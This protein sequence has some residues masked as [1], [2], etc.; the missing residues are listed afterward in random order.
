VQERPHVPPAVPRERLELVSGGRLQVLTAGDGFATRAD[1]FSQQVIQVSPDGRRLAWAEATGMGFAILH[2]RDART[3]RVVAQGRLADFRFSPDSA[4]IAALV[5]GKVMRVDL[6]TGSTTTTELDAPRWVEWNAMGLVV[7]HRAP[8]GRDAITLLPRWTHPVTVIASHAPVSRLTTAAKTGKIAWFEDGGAT[9]TGRIW[10][11]DLADD[12]PKPRQAGTSVGGRVLNAE[13]APDGSAYAWV[14]GWGVFVA[15]GAMPRHEEAD[16]AVHSLWYGPDGEL[17][18]AS[19]KRVVVI[20]ERGRHEKAVAART[21]RFR[22]DGAGLIIVRERDAVVWDFRHRAT[23]SLLAPRA[24]A[25]WAAD[26][27]AGGVV[28]W[29]VEERPERLSTPR[30]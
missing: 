8:D 22:R 20:D 4:E 13:M 25:V 21:M 2:V 7:L 18:F 10:E 29:T 17:A 30:S 5:D 11:M 24:N 6:D 19:P 9:G 26:S 12:D 28:T 3:D 23:S 15:D 14:T 27:F 16:D 1:G